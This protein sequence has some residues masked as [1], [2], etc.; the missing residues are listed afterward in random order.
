MNFTKA[1]ICVDFSEPSKKLIDSIPDLKKVGLKEVVFASV[2]NVHPA[3]ENVPFIKETYS[4]KRQLTLERLQEMSTL[5]KGHD[6]ET[7]EIVS[8]GFTGKELLNIAVQEQADLIVVGSH[9]KGVVKTIL[10]GSTSFEL[11]RK[12]E[13]PVLIEKFKDVEKDQFDLVSAEKF[14]KVVLPVDFSQSSLKV[15]DFVK[16]KDFIKDVIL[17][18][19]V[20]RGENIEELDKRTKEIQ[21]KLEGIKNDLIAAGK[22]VEVRLKQ[23]TPS[24]KIMEIA[25]DDGASLIM[26]SKGGAG[27]IAE[28][29]IGSTAIDIARYS[30]VPVLLFPKFI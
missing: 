16:D 7:K 6:V 21:E 3:D 23:G 2:I 30:K 25:E 29:L 11:A 27:N 12:S 13:I 9:G 15:I 8:F 20:A 4:E 18:K 28:L 5:A 17:V 10:L 26:I 19:V 14:K 22:N 1:L 24:E